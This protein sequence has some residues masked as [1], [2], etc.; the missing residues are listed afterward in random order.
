MTIYRT[1][2]GATQFIGAFWVPALLSR[3]SISRRGGTRG[4][5]DFAASALG[6]FVASLPSA[7]LDPRSISCDKG[8]VSSLRSSSAANGAG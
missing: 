1:T 6:R 5:G 7:F 3:F 2:R 8:F 4:L